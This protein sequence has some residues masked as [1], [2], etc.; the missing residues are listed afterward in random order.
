MKKSDF[1]VVGATYA[2]ALFFYVM[3]VELPPEA[4]TYPLGLIIALAVLNTL[5]LGQATVK[6]MRTKTIENDLPVIFKDF[7]FLQFFGVI[8]GC[9]LF[10]VLMYTVGYYLAA[11]IYLIG[12]MLFLKVPKFHILLAIVA[13]VALVY[14]VF[15]LFLQVPLPHGVLF[16]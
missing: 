9:V 11:A 6:W 15:S 5:Y 3:T 7:Q 4:Q 12:T 1:A 13:L 8:A 16:D 2:I 14:A 10:L